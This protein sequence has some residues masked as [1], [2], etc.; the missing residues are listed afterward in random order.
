M[1]R[2][3]FPKNS[4]GLQRGSCI[5]SNHPRIKDELNLDIGMMIPLGYDGTFVRS[6]IFSW[7]IADL[8]D[9]IE[10]GY[11]KIDAVLDLSH[12]ITEKIFSI[13]VERKEDENEFV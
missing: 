5:I 1:S 2:N 6:G 10:K 3:E 12:P 7:D 9:E 4:L 13:A 11:W 8:V